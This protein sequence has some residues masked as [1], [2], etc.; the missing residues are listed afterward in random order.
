[1]RMIPLFCLLAGPAL[2]QVTT[3]DKALQALQP[4]VQ[5][6]AAG[7][8]APA[9]TPARPAVKPIHSATSAHR[10]TRPPPAHL[11]PKSQL[12][13]VPLAPPPNPV[14]APPPPVL[15]QHA[16]EAP[17]PVPVKPDAV[18]TVT[19]ITDGARLTFGPGTS[20]LNPTTE[21]TLRLFAAQAAQDKTLE[22]TI[23]AWAPGTPEDPSTPRR[24]SLD[25]ALAARAVLIN[26]G[27]ESE[28]IHAVAKGFNGIAGGPPDR[29]D[30]ISTHPRSAPPGT[31]LPPPP[32]TTHTTAA[33][34]P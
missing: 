7:T 16:K 17:A 20:D 3:D 14:I 30:I 8:Q 2:A 13:A 32:T 25:R 9:T 24:L 18:G 31:P 27:V 15:P 4:A 10:A 29:L 6:P 22:I 34:P 12:P 33:K 26:H 28:R 23:T 5:A 1:M 19:K 11:P 21:G